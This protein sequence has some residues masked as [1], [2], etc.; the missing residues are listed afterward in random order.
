MMYTMKMNLYLYE[1]TISNCY[2]LIP[3]LLLLNKLFIVKL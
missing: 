1:F 3:N 2:Y